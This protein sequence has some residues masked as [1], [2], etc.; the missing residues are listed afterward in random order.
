[1]NKDINDGKVLDTIREVNQKER[2]ERLKQ[3]SEYQQNMRKKAEKRREEYEKKL[4][5]ERLSLLKEKQGLTDTAQ[6]QEKQPGAEK[7]KISV[8]QKISSFIYCNKA[9]VI[10][11]TFFVLAAAFLIYDLVTKDR[12][13]MTVMVLVDDPY[14]EQSIDKMQE[15]FAQY[16]DDVNSNGETNV[17]FYYM[18]VSQ[19]ADQYTYGAN[20]TKLYAM[21]QLPDTIM[22]IADEKAKEQIMAD[23]TLYNLENDYDSNDNVSGYGFYFSDTDF[24]SQMDYKGTQDCDSYYIGLRKVADNVS[25]KEVM[26]KNFDVAYDALSKFITEYSK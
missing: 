5:E 10:V 26:Q 14:F 11:G 3:Q 23:D 20:A 4:N 16:I 9:M 8:A 7:K 24:L 12:P 6:T 18:P 2:Q 19:D 22:V 21:M 1:M 17:T 15:K 13:D 25:K